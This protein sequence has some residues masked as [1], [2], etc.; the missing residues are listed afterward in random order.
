MET[1][2]T[3]IESAPSFIDLIAR[4]IFNSSVAFI[5]LH[6]V[7]KQYNKKKTFIFNLFIFNLIIFGLSTVLTRIDLSVGSI[8]ALC[9]AFA[10]SMIAMEVSVFIAVPIALIGGAA[11]GAMAGIII[12]KGKVQAFIA[13]LVTM[14]LLRGVTMVY[15]DGRPISTGFTDVA[16]AFAFAPRFE[17]GGADQRRGRPTKRPRTETAREEG[18]EGEEGVT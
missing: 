5:I 10:A 13:T 1:I 8:L 4:L 16:D 17:Q 7:Y 3:V 14:T 6:F 11:L 15:T 12:S 9:G 2:K 18:E